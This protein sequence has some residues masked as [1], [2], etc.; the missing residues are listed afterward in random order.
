MS[1]PLYLI[2]TKEFNCPGWAVFLGCVL[3]LG[4]SAT[5]ILITPIVIYGDSIPS[6]IF[7]IVVAA[8]LAV[9]CIVNHVIKYLSG[10]SDY[11][12]IVCCLG[13]IYTVILIILHRG[14]GNH[15]NADESYPS[16]EERE[17]A[18]QADLKLRNIYYHV[19]TNVEVTCHG[20]NG[21]I[22]PTG[23]KLYD[24]S[25]DVEFVF[26]NGKGD[27]RSKSTSFSIE[28]DE[29]FYFDAKDAESRYEYVLGPSDIDNF[30]DWMF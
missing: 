20:L 13:I 28:D 8:I 4:L 10:R 30:T 22:G 1:F 3:T 7:L 17:K 26:R 15:Y 14:E 16:H 6:L 11:F 25:V 24:Y 21:K 27:E 12:S 9:G 5:V 29:F 19:K 2:T 18:Y 23:L